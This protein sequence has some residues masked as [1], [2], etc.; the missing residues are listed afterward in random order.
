MLRY[1]FA[2]KIK[3]GWF[4]YTLFMVTTHCVKSARI[5]SYSCPYLVRM[6]ENTDQNNSE[7][8][9]FS[10]NDVESI[11]PEDCFHC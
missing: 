7:Y 8:G 1:F 3:N 6:R 11:C 10:R 5:R 9:H 2:S 4:D